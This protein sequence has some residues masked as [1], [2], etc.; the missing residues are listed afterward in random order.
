MGCMLMYT[1]GTLLLTMQ[2]KHISTMHAIIVISQK[3]AYGG[4]RIF[5][6][7]DISLENTPTSH[8]VRLA[9]VICACS[10]S[11]M[12][13]LSALAYAIPVMSAFVLLLWCFL[14]NI[15]ACTA[16]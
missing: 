5:E 1:V 13:L 2:N 12:L 8:A 4:G 14:L 15:T 3:Y 6:S 10:D 7:C 16:A 9:L 11:A